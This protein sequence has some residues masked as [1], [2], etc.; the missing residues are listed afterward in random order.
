MDTGGCPHVL[1]LQMDCTGY[2]QSIQTALLKISGDCAHIVV[3]QTAE[4][5]LG[6]VDTGQNS[7]LA[8]CGLL[9]FLDD[10]TGETHS[11]LEVAAELIDTLVGSGRHEGV[12]QIAVCHMDLNSICAGLHGALC[13]LAVALDQLINLLGRYFYGD[14]PAVCSCDG[15]S[16]FDRSTSILGVAFRTCILQLDGD[17]RA[18]R[19]T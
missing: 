8:F 3:V 12:D 16:S 17:F 5:I 6:A 10:Q 11:V 2:V 1:I 14:I 13:S 19:M 4:H 18:F 9:D 15:R 7:D